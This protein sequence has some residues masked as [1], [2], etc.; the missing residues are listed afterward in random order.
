MRCPP[1][2][3]TYRDDDITQAVTG[4]AEM[5][6]NAPVVPE[7]YSGKTLLCTICGYLQLHTWPGSFY[8]GSTAV[9][10]KY[11]APFRLGSLWYLLAGDTLYKDIAIESTL[12][13]AGSRKEF[14]NAK[15]LKLASYIFPA[16]GHPKGLVILVH[17]HGCT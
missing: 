5:A 14:T 15:G 7:W 3:S 8:K 1:R 13:P 4:P 12:G 17:G 2:Y 11:F 9:P 6:S 10:L 16:Q